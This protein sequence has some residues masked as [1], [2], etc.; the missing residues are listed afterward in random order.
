MLNDVAVADVSVAAPDAVGRE[1]GLSVGIGRDDLRR[2][3]RNALP[4]VERPVGPDVVGVVRRDCRRTELVGVPWASRAGSPAGTWMAGPDCSSSCVARPGLARAGRGSRVGGGQVHGASSSPRPE[5]RKGGAR[6]E[7][8][9]SGV[10]AERRRICARSYCLG[11][12]GIDRDQAWLSHRPLSVPRLTSREA[13]HVKRGVLGDDA[14]TAPQHNFSPLR[15]VPL[16][17]GNREV[18]IC[19]SAVWSDGIHVPRPVC[20]KET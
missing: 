11:S 10:G 14:S 4:I 20:R 8:G 6:R 18:Y 12:S 13:A 7:G 19:D 5:D 9:G 17:V 16:R 1:A 3:R 2:G 15:R